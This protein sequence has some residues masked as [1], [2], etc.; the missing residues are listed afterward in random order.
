[1]TPETSGVETE[2]AQPTPCPP[3]SSVI[4]AH[5]G[6]ANFTQAPRL[7]KLASVPD[8]VAE[9]TEIASGKAAGYCGVAFASLPAA[10]T[11]STPAARARATAPRSCLG[12]RSPYRLTFTTAAPW[13]T[14]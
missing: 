1:M 8:E 9:A 13:S 14:A 7:E 5:S 12:E 6:A 2:V 3:P 10:A 11:T 4:G